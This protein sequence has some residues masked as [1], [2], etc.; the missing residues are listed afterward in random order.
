MKI[1]FKKALVIAKNIFDQRSI[2]KFLV[3]VV[4]S[5]LYL[6]FATLLKTSEYTQKFML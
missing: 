5:K 4:T 2:L 1:I 3:S 6:I